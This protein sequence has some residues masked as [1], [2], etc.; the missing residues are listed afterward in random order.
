MPITEKT[1]ELYPGSKDWIQKYLYLIDEGK[2]VLEKETP[3]W[4]YVSSDLHLLFVRHGILFGSSRSPIFFKAPNADKWTKEEKVK[5]LLFESLLFIHL[6]KHR[7]YEKEKFIEELLDYYSSFAKEDGIPFLKFD[8][9]SEKAPTIELEQ[10][11]SS[12]VAIKSSIISTNKWI[13]YIENSFVFLDVI[14]FDHYLNERPAVEEEDFENLKFNTLLSIIQASHADEVVSD[15]EKNIFKT[16]LTAASLP[17]EKKQLLKEKFK[18][19]AE[20][21][22]YFSSYLTSELFRFFLLDMSLLTIYT[23]YE[24]DDSEK[25]FLHEFSSFLNIDA[26]QYFKASIAVQQFVLNNEDFV[27][28]LVKNKS[29]ERMLNSLSNRWIKILSRN[30]DKFVTELLESKELM[31]LVSKAAVTE[32]T[33]EEKLKVKEQFKDLIKSMPSLAVFMLP[34]G[35]ILLPLLLK[36]IPGLLPSSFRDNEIQERK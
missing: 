15:R 21:E 36:V 35:A 34:G 24:V 7:K 28:A 8:F 5:F 33:T 31:A 17:G 11:L 1:I 12:R 13:K 4:A 18:T 14:L 9:L 16:F 30:K 22:D 23:S 32:L 25:Q 6:C 2:I 20:N 3:D 19:N 29:Y 27:P 26:D 10:I